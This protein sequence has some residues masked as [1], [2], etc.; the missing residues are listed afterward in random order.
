MRCFCDICKEWSEFVYRSIL[1]LAG[2]RWWWSAI[3]DHRSMIP[4]GSCRFCLDSKY[5]RK[6]FFFLSMAIIYH[7]IVNG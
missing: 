6:L 5:L 3:L 2:E 7:P 1:A 4:A